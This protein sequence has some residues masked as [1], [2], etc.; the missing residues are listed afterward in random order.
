MI[1]G[2]DMEYNQTAADGTVYNNGLGICFIPKTH[3]TTG[4]WNTSNTTEGGYKSSYVHT[5]VLPGIVTKLQNVL[6]S[7]I[8]QRNV[9]LSSSTNGN[10]SNA[11]T[12]TTA[13]ATLMSIGQMTGTFAE[14]WNKYDDGEANHMLPIFNYTDFK[15]GSAF[16]SRCIWGHH[17]SYY[18]AWC[19]NNG[20]S[21]VDAYSHDTLG[22]RPLIYLR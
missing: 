20:G 16:W 5:T 11:Y 17:N 13:Y 4:Q 1:A 9:L 6:G 14:N 21:I 19:V 22:V 12:W 18:R 7:H 15:T 2:F 3:V 8:V 10:I